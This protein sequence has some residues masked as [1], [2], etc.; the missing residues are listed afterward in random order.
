MTLSSVPDDLRQGDIF[1]NVRFFLADDDGELNLYKA[2]CMLLTNTCDCERNDNLEFAA[3]WPLS[4][5]FPVK[6]KADDLKRNKNYQYLYIPD[7]RLEDDIIDF[8]SIVSLPREYFLEQLG[9]METSKV[10][11]LSWV[12]YYVFLAKLTVFF[13]R[14]E[15]QSVNKLR[16]ADI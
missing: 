4:K 7:M 3:I 6:E 10:V 5:I 8:G 11:S 14:P 12:G 9:C 1:E 2:R 16:D 15:D 13:M